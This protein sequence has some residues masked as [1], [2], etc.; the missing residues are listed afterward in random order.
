MEFFVFR[1]NKISILKNREWGG[2]EVK[3]L[4]FVTGQ[5]V[6]LPD[7][8]GFQET[9]NPEE[10]MALIRAAA[11]SVLSAKLLIQI[12][13][14]RDGHVMTFGDTGYA[15]YTS[16]K[17]PVSFN[18]S[19]LAFELDSDIRELGSRIDAIVNEP[20][21]N[22]FA[23]DLIALAGA[24]HHPASALGLAIAKFVFG[25]VI[26]NLLRDRDDQIGVL[27]QSFNRFEHY[28]HGE[29]K[30]DDVPDLSNNILIDYSIFGTEY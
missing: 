29:R 11:L 8:S 30:R 6:N 3:L 14:V 26:D 5:D 9:R 7:L 23:Q 15:L 17:I 25:V 4:S 16:D 1:I 13:H 12:E 24:A 28:P 20:G 19:L 10:Q 22:Q 2:A 18:W 21:F 27:Y